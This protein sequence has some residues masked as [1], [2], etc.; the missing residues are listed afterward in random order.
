LLDCIFDTSALTKA[1]HLVVRDRQERASLPLY[2]YIF[3]VLLLLI[4]TQSTT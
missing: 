3:V 1:G 2:P 4:C